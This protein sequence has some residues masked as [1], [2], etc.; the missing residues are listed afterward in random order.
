MS[1][2]IPGPKR[3]EVTTR[4]IE[5]LD[6]QNEKGIAKYG[7]T[8]DQAADQYYDWKLMA[9]EEMVDLIQYQ[10]KEIMRLE[11]LLNPI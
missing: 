10:Q 1:G 3:P 11:R 8:I 4:I 5:L 9:M 6:K 7:S 2:Q